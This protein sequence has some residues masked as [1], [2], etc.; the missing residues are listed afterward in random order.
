M[1]QAWTGN[2]LQV[3]DLSVHEWR[4]PS[5]GGQQLLADVRRDGVELIKKSPFLS[6]SSSAGASD[7]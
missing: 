1:V 3:I 4:H 5:E 2:A 7:G 6:S